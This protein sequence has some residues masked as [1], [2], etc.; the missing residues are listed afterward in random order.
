MPKVEQKK[1]VSATFVRSSEGS[2]PSIEVCLPDGIGETW[3][4]DSI[5]VGASG[6]TPNERKKI[7]AILE[8]EI[9]SFESGDC[10]TVF[11]EMLRELKNYGGMCK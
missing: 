4:R 3:W 5:S 10:P 7:I 9:D 11:R 8:K 6:A 1:K 2:T